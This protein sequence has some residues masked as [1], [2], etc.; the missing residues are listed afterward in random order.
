MQHELKQLLS[1]LHAPWLPAIEPGLERVARF[2][3]FLGDPHK[4]LPA[5]IHI[6][7]TNG[8]GSLLAYLLAIFKAAGLRAHAY[9]SPH[10]VRFNERIILNGAPIQDAV[11]H[12]LLIRVHPFMHRQSATFFESTTA[13]AFLAFSEHPADVVILETGMGGRLDATNVVDRPALTVITPIGMDH[14]SYLGHTIEAIAYEKACIIKTGAPCVIGRQ[15]PA[16]RR[17]ITEYAVS[18]QSPLYRMGQEFSVSWNGDACFYDSAARHRRIETSLLGDF[19]MDNAATA[20][21]CIEALPQFDI[22]DYHIATGLKRAIWHGRLQRLTAG[23]LQD[24]MHDDMALILDGGHNVHCAQ[25]LADWLQQQHKDVY[26]ICGMLKGKDAQGYLDI[27]ANV[28]LEIYTVPIMDEPQAMDA[29]ALYEIARASGHRAYKPENIEK[30]LQT[31]A[32]RAKNP[33]IVCI[34]G[35]LYLVGNVLAAGN[36]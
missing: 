29:A 22:A 7:G 35:S 14:Q 31:I 8:K 20:I 21:A 3:A 15:L 12:D 23:P 24:F 27:L 19:Q 36:T 11:L 25:V 16:A 10:L 13:A 2:L 32:Q 4:K 33:S 5:V 18:K 17:V 6:A 28:A 1:Q 9:S 30:A 26:V 34:C